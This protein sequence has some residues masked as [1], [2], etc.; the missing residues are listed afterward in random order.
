MSS[1]ENTSV[2]WV[3]TVALM[4][5]EEGLRL[6]LLASPCSTAGTAH[7]SGHNA[8][9]QAHAAH[10]TRHTQHTA[11]QGKRMGQGDGWSGR[12][13]GAAE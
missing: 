13:R 5:A 12:V 10:C 6:E 11:G 2:P 7:C 3:D 4:E 9:W 1:L 8:L